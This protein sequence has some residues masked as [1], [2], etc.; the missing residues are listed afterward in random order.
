MPKIEIYTKPGCPFCVRAK[1]LLD[2]KGVRYE[3]HDVSKDPARAREAVERSGLMTVPQVFVDGESLGGS[4][5]L[6]ALD[7][8]G[9]LDG[10]LGIAARG[11]SGE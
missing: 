1:S 8:Q 9:A 10:K 3:E 7:A 5:D 11:A 2:R 6:T 4:D